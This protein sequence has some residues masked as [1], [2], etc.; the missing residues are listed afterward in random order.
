MTKPYEPQ[1]AIQ[2]TPELRPPSKRYIARQLEDE[3]T[4]GLERANEV[5]D[6]GFDNLAMRNMLQHEVCV[7]HIKR[8]VRKYAQVIH[9]IQ[10]EVAVGK[11]MVEPLSIF[12]HAL[13]DIH[14]ITRLEATGEGSRQTSNAT[15]K[16]EY[17][18][19]I[20]VKVEP[21]HSFHHGRDFS[22]AR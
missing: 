21:L 18:I 10:T 16:V 13:R 22:F 4:I 15:T 11:L 7:D 9:G 2:T 17:T 20:N 1:G 8:I 14:A 6:V 12:N 5:F 19:R 3:Q